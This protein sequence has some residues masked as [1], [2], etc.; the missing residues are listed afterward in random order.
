M[1]RM[2]DEREREFRRRRFAQ[3]LSVMGE[4]ASA[5]TSPDVVAEEREARRRELVEHLDR[6][7]DDRDVDVFRS[8]MDRLSK[9]SQFAEL[10][11]GFNLGVGMFLNQ[12]VKYS[13]D[14][15]RLTD[16][17]V[18]VAEAPVDEA[19]ADRKLRRLLHHVDIVRV[20]AQPAPRHAVTMLSLFWWCRQ[21]SVWPYVRPSSED[22]MRK[23]G[24]LPPDLDTVELYPWYREAIRSLGDDDQLMES[25]LGWFREHPWTGLDPGLADR[26]R[27]A[28]ELDERWDGDDYPLGLR[29]IA[30]M[31]I[32]AVLAELRILGD[33]AE[34]AL[35]DAVG[36]ALRRHVSGEVPAGM[37]GRFRTGVWL[38]W[39]LREATG[40]TEAPSIMM[41]VRSSGV[42]IGFLPGRR[43]KGWAASIREQLEELHPAGLEFF[44]IW[45]DDDPVDQEI[46]EFLVGRSFGFDQVLGTE[47][48]VDQ[49]VQ[50]GAAAQPMFD[51]VVR[52][53]VEPTPPGGVELP[54]M[55]ERFVIETGYPTDEDDAVA[56]ERSALA[57]LLQP[58]VLAG[59]DLTDFR[60]V[61]NSSRYGSVGNQPTLDAF[62][63]DVGPS[64]T[65]RVI[66]LL[67]VL[68]W[69]DAAVEERI[70]RCL[71][72]DDL[73]V[74][75]L[76]EPVIMKLLSVCHP[77]RFIP[78]FSLGGEYGKLALLTALGEHLPDVVLGSGARQVQAND[79]LRT[80]LEQFLPDD[81]WGQRRFAFWVRDD[82]RAG[83][84]DPLE[85][86]VDD[87]YLPDRSFIDELVELLEDKRQIVLYG[88]PGTGKTFI[89]RKL[90]AALAGPEQ[91]RRFVQFHP[92]TSY[93]DFF[94]GYRPRADTDGN[95]T[96]SLEP[97]PFAEL[98]D[99]A[100]QDPR[101][102]V[103]VIDELNRANIPKVFG[104]LL[105]L[106]E[107]RE[108]PVV[109]LY[110]PEF[111]LP[112]NLWLIATMNTADR[113]IASLD[114]ALRRRFHFVPIFP[115]EG[116]MEGLL[117][118]YLDRHHGDRSWA[119]LVAMVNAELRERLGNGDLLIGPSHF[120]R[121]DLDQ[122][123][124]ERIWRYNVE[125]LIEDLFYGDRAAISEFRWAAVLDRFTNDDDVTTAI[126]DTDALNDDQQAGDAPT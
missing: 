84:D 28:E 23:L 63:R 7:G 17:V 101:R 64:A 35:S 20:G 109:P 4:G 118:R 21:P 5:G 94:E 43:G 50:I 75:G 9:S 76:G 40:W 73:G 126:P 26:L 62:C 104:E 8:S 32:T 80:L 96:Y 99:H 110:R 67:R 79:Q 102:H 121:E 72:E 74:A 33:H 108:Q 48:L 29:R 103:L 92:S 19:D 77:D 56:S 100:S 82:Q 70:D 58:D 27:R 124:M 123:V 88:P 11:P 93:E 107:Y 22:A 39:K 111:A 87:C 71:D 53:A 42:Q 12:L 97:G 51:H 122:K 38:K 60:R 91:L 61:Y 14:L 86:V 1:H 55:F 37:T 115:D 41:A 114:A 13:S 105:F 117:G 52:S 106:L 31:N 119:D 78:V 45:R 90:A 116:P 83:G 44:S 18:S 120:L 66:D 95:L 16:L 112:D 98:A 36:R 81:A 49:I 34:E 113:S 3:I 46:G 65:G 6:L 15:S 47:G 10:F 57:E 54:S 59:L 24:W 85:S 68:L 89:A 2:I 125:P 30:R 69:D 25:A